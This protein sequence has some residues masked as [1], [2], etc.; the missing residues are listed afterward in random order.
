MEFKDTRNGYRLLWVSRLLIST[1][2]GLSL[3]G[4]AVALVFLVPALAIVCAALAIGVG[5]LGVSLRWDVF[6]R[7]PRSNYD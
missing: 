4:G 3:L 7:L 5:F 1:A 2:G 6:D